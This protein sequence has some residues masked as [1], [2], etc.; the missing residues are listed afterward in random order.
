MDSNPPH[1]SSTTA[2]GAVYLHNLYSNKLTRENYNI[3]KATV[4][5]ILKGHSLYGFI[6]CSNP[7]P[8]SIISTPSET[9]AATV[10]S[11]PPYMA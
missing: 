8:S 6:D 10:A 5:P 3:G 9:G 4:A 1:T 2:S 7:C 11:N